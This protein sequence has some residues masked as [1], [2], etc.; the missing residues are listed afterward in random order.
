MNKDEVL[1]SR[2]TVFDAALRFA[3]AGQAVAAAQRALATARAEY[4]EAGEALRAVR[5]TADALEANAVAEITKAEA[6]A[7]PT[8]RAG[9]ALNESAGN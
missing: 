8:K 9:F 6:A 4:D 1:K 3:R 7:V 2:G 5:S